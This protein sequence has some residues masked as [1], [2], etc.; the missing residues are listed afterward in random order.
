MR[1]VHVIVEQ[2][3]MDGTSGAFAVGAYESLASAQ[4]AL[5][6]WRSRGGGVRCSLKTVP[7]VEGRG[8]RHGD[9]GR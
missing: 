2:V 6:R 4:L 5:E 1:E 9:G 3:D 7:L 8:P